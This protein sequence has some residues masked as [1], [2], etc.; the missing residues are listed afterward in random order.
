MKNFKKELR[1]LEIEKLIK[2]SLVALINKCRNF[3]GIQNSEYEY[4]YKYIDIDKCKKK[5]EF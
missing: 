4:D 1:L 3:L 2:N 5:R